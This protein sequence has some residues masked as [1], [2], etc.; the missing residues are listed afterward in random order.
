M[1]GETLRSTFVARAL[2]AVAAAS[3]GC[4]TPGAAEP[5]GNSSSRADGGADG[6]MAQLPGRIEL[7]VTTDQ[8]VPVT[9]TLTDA[10]GAVVATGFGVAGVPIVVSG[11]TPGSGYAIAVSTAPDGGVTCGGGSE[12]F[13]VAPSATV[14]VTVTLLCTPLCGVW[15]SVPQHPTGTVGDAIV[16]DATG[17]GPIEPALRFVWT[18]VDPTIGHLGPTGQGDAGPTSSTT[19][20]FCDA[21]GATE[22]SLTVFDVPPSE[23][24]SCAPILGTVSV[25]AVCLAPDAGAAADG[26]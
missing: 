16:L 10:A 13:S 15:R 26:G 19:L 20:F 11:V 6:T 12:R 8:G 24:A 4:F 23:D 22:L 5:A 9:W 21:P 18:V 17:I 14:M 7:T 3:I 1:R 25:V 2:L